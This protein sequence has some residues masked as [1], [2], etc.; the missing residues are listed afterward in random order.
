MHQKE[1]I[2][3]LDWLRISAFA[4]LILFHSWQPFNSFHWLIKSPYQTVLADILTVFFHTWRLYLIFFVSGVGTFLAL[5]SR[6]NKFFTDR[7]QRLIIPFI[8]GIIVIVP[9][10]YYFQ[11]LQKYPGTSFLNFIAH[12]P[13][14]IASRPYKFDIFQWLLELGIHLW[15]LP[16]L[17]IMTVALYPLFNRINLSPA[18][19]VLTR[20]PQL[21]WLFVLPFIFTLIL[22][23]PIFPEY[24]S[25]TDFITY[26]IIFL[27]GF[28]FIKQHVQLLPVLH[29]N[30]TM[31]LI[32]GIASSLLLIGCLLSP[33][34]RKAA[35][36]PSYSINHVIISILLGCSA[37]TWPLYFVSLFSRR[38]NYSNT[39]LPELN[40]SV[41]PVYIIHQTII[42]AGGFF[43]IKYVGNGLLEFILIVLT[44][45]MI[46]IPVYLFIKRFGI[47]R[48]LFGM[49]DKRDKIIRA[50]LSRE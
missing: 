37:F 43:I 4:L 2:H 50:Q 6:G 10:Q 23:K 36:N 12:Y 42:V 31:L 3:Y 13:G 30:S 49:S 34:L 24:T 46:S 32:S 40:K 41:L 5:R 22:L 14:F 45:F 48:F 17:F 21:L 39:L 35:F 11:K 47:T 29:K 1:R 9:C 15:Y 20:R 27:Y 7:F 18:V 25:V 16:S 38:F 8:F 33:S 28:F 44:T 26:A 19:S